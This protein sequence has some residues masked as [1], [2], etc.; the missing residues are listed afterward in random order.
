[1]SQT[2][3]QFQDQFFIISPPTLAG[4]PGGRVAGRL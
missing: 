4:A 1:M 3:A 2:S